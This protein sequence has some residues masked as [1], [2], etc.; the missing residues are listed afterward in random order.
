MPFAFS[1]IEPAVGWEVYAVACYHFRIKTDKRPDGGSTQ[2]A[3]HA[4][5]INREGKYQDIDATRLLEYG[6]DLICGESMLNPIYYNDKNIL[7]YESPYGNIIKS[8]NGL[9]VTEGAS[10]ETAAIAINLAKKMYTGQISVTGSKEFKEKILFANNELDLKVK[11]SDTEMELQNI[12][13]GK[14]KTDNN[15]KTGE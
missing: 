12:N 7:L 13:Y 2:G 11:F 14:E 15:E 3:I 1:L 10:Q 8:K 4:E 9:H 5:Y 6:T